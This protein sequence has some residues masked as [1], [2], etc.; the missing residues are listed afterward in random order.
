M[1]TPV[2]CENCPVR[3]LLPVWCGYYDRYCEASEDAEIERVE[4]IEKRWKS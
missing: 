4:D 3:E 2:T 1:K